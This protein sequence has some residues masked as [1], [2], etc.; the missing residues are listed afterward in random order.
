MKNFY[1]AADVADIE[2]LVDQVIALKDQGLRT[3][4]TQGPGS[5]KRMLLLF[6]NSSLR[7]RLSTEIAARSLGMEVISMDM[8]QSWKWEITPGVVMSADSAEH[9]RDAA[10][11]ISSYVDIVGIRCFPTLQDRAADKRDALIKTFI[12]HAD[13]PVVNLESAQ[14]H[15][16]QSLTDMAT[17]RAHF[18][19]KV[20]RIV[21]SW[22]P[23]PK[24]LPHAVA[25][26]FLQW[27]G[28]MQW[29]VTIT[30]P[31]GYALPEDYTRG[32]HYEP[33][34]RKALTDADVVY[35]KNW[36]SHD[37]YGQVLNTDPDWMMT[38]EKMALTNQ[39]LCMH[40]MPIRRNVVATDEVLD[41]D[42]CI[43]Y[44]QAAMR[45]QAAQ[46]VLQELLKDTGS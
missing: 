20:P 17:I 11:V 35:L 33:D 9:I 6:F 39:G 36:S 3:T 27:A 25:Q 14:L 31:D 21:L 41:S 43:M 28:A 18:A 23:H 46:V 45:E 16:L 42:C 37:P 13:V 5:G 15:P 24:A 8:G 38:T 26:S 4:A 34:Q 30:H 44:E 7:T 12:R 29:Q 10:Q 32:H 1:S 22:A 19:E 2:R 40:C